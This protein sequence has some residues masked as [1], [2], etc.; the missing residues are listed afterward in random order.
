[1]TASLFLYFLF[2]LALLGFLGVVTLLLHRLSARLGDAPLLMYL[3]ALTAL[4]QA[5]TLGTLSVFSDPLNL[6]LR[7]ASFVVLP[8][9][10]MGLLV[11]Y[12]VDGASR[13]RVALIGVSFVG[14]VVTLFRLAPQWRIEL[15]NATFITAVP[16][17]NSPVGVLASAV[18]LAIDL[19][20]MIPVYQALS[21]WRRR[22]PSMLAAILAFFAAILLDALLYPLLSSFSLPQFSALL[23][24]HLIGKTLAALALSPLLAVYLINIAPHLPESTAAHPR[25][26]L[27]FFTARTRDYERQLL[28]IHRLTTDLVQVWDQNVIFDRMIAASEELLG[29]DASTIYLLAED[30]VT[31]SQAIR[32]NLSLEYLKHLMGG[33]QGLPAET[34][35][36][37]RQPVFVSDTLN[38]PRYGE[39]IH[40]MAQ[41][42]VHALLILPVLF[43]EAPLGALV[44]YYNQPH[45]FLPEDVQLGL[46]LSQ[47]LAI[48]LQNSRLYQ[49]SRQR[50]DELDTLFKAAAAVS[51]SLDLNQ[52]L[53]IVAEQIAQAVNVRGCGFSDYRVADDSVVLLAETRPA[54]WPENPEA[55]LPYS[56]D[57]FPVT[58]RVLESGKPVLQHTSD[59]NLDPSER[60]FME[61]SGIQTMLMFPMVLKDRTIGL[62]ELYDDRPDLVF[63]SSELNLVQAIAAHAAQVIENARLY[64]RTQEHAIELEARVQQRT[65]E[66]RAAKERIEGILVSVPDAILVLNEENH[67]IQANPAGEGLITLAEL[68]NAVVFSLENLSKLAN[69]RFREEKPVVE[70]NQRAYQAIAST[71]PAGSQREGAVIVL[72]DVT[73]FRELDEMKTRFV[74]DVS[75][76]LRTPLTNLA[77]YLDLLTA[78]SPPDEKSR[79]YLSTLRRETKR[80]TDLIE[81]LL[82]ISRLEANR[83]AIHMQ[84]VDAN[85][86]VTEMS[87][88]RAQM[89]EQRMLA[90]TCDTEARL[91]PALA[92]PRLLTQVLS[93]LLTNALNYSPPRAAIR[94][95]TQVQQWAGEHWVTIG[96]ADEGPGISQEEVSHLF[97]RFYR[98]AAGHASSAPGT[99]L[100][101]A[102]S[103]EIMERMAGLITVESQPGKGSR[104]TIWMRAVL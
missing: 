104:F 100:G 85:R 94:L 21:N 33:Y 27:D 8:V 64:Q 75:H 54:A 80:L 6:L 32:H 97:T 53:H 88:D 51:T 69:S 20:V 66:L 95:T 46:T 48:A 30:G 61:K 92:D 44:V 59:P 37:T 72:R 99:G 28:T 1:M 19:T 101:L 81:D 58:R 57:H 63:T 15:V 56:L 25:R 13:A 73:R 5:G 26:A 11:I 42:D 47:T 67:I 74:S 23:Y 55:W 84:P 22:Y 35:F 83:L 65:A 102:I 52:V 38:D 70:I 82:T 18:A 34:A 14:L 91:P 43:H 49:S 2:A 4:M 60:D 96:V 17:G 12:I 29:A 41:Y 77:L 71:L 10:L 98:G 9:L 86:V 39:R 50:S 40:F 68:E 87:L 103:K 45:N 24:F 16:E 76:E 78:S 79:K 93:N 36:R 62:V 7:T 90:L 31:I 89:A 3:G